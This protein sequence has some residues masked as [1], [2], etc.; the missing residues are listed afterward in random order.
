MSYKNRINSGLR[1]QAICDAV[2][3]PFEFQRDINPESVSTYINSN[4]PLV[5]SD[6]TQ[7]AL[8]GFEAI[9]RA[10]LAQG[11]MRDII[12]NEFTQSYLDWHTTQVGGFNK[13]QAGLLGLGSMYSVQS[14]GNTCLASLR[15]IRNKKEV[16]NDSK[17]CGSV[18]RLIPMVGLFDP[19]YGFSESEVIDFA[20]ITGDIT[21]KHVENA[22]AIELYMTTAKDILDRKSIPHWDQYQ[23]ISDI[24]EGWTALE[25]VEMAIWSV[26]KA[27]NFD[28]LLRL[29]VAHDG[30]SDSVA[31]VAGSLW[32]LTGKSFPVNA[33]FRLDAYD[34][35]V[36]VSGDMQ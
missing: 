5:I 21:H 10:K 8:F 24:G 12:R 3:N 23:N 2:G 32:G 13:P 4:G 35:I 22:D 29:S 28:H 18:M 7:M 30:D 15:N 11:E 14:P 26:T 27:K 33:V 25:C 36:H 9:Q 19:A 31:S 20:K 17:G 34:A 6:D 16:D 1:V